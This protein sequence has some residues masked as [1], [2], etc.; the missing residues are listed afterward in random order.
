MGKTTSVDPSS[1]TACCSVIDGID[2]TSAGI[3]GVTC[4]LTGIVTGIKFF[5]VQFRLN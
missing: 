2:Q 1:A 4:T 5:K 3:P